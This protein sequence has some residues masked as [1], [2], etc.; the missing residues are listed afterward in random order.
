MLFTGWGDRMGKTEPEV[1]K[2]ARARGGR[3]NISVKFIP[4][5]MQVDR[6]CHFYKCESRKNLDKI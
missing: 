6:L 4:Q 5:L 2:T 3:V 1:L